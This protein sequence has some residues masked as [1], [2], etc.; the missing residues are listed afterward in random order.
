[1]LK[2]NQ[3][4]CPGRL[5]FL[6]KQIY[7]E[8]ISGSSLFVTEFNTF[9]SSGDEIF[10]EEHYN[11][12]HSTAAIGFW[13]QSTFKY[14]YLNVET[15][16][17]ILSLPSSVSVEQIYIEVFLDHHCLQPNSILFKSGGDE[18]FLEDK[19]QQMPLF[20]CSYLDS[21]FNQHFKILLSQW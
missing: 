3:V 18:I 1:M 13:V 19:L 21:G 11:R 4:Y 8:A 15:E 14:Y 2:P 12:C 9:N 10:L 5:L 17:S 6:L 7:I 20:C 16:S